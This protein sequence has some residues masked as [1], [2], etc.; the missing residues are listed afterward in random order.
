MEDNTERKEFYFGYL[1][2]KEQE[3]NAPL[4]ITNISIDKLRPFSR[5]TFKLYEGQRFTDMVGS[6]KA[7][8]IFIPIIVQPIEF[9]DGF[10]EI[11]SGHNR[12]EA[13]K[14]AGFTE[15]PAVIRK[16]LTRDEAM[17]IVTESNLIQ[18]SFAN[19]SHSERAAAMSMHHE[20]IK[21]QGK[22]TDLIN[23]IENLLNQVQ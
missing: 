8:G 1:N 12:T 9:E 3:R 22:R 7:N 19:L 4:Q 21:S 18:R 17:L 6:V 16:H 10:Y 5:H 13:A 11:L 2:K 14:A 20:A 23:E 15:I